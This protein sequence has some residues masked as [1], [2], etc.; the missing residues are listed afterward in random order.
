MMMFW[1]KNK[2]DYQLSHRPPL[3]TKL[4]DLTFVVFDTETTGFAIG[5]K[6]RLIEI[7][8][9][10]VEGFQVTDET[11]HTYVNPHRPI[12]EQITELTGISEE[13][14]K[15]APS[16]LEAIESFF[17]FIEKCESSGLVGHYLA[18]D[19]LVLKKE[20][21]RHKT[22][23]EDPLTFDTLDIL[24]YLVPSWEMR[25]LEEYARAF[26][27]K[28]FDRHSA[29]GDAL[30]TAHL[31][32]ELLH[33]LEEYGKGTLGDLMEVTLANDESRALQF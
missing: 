9:V 17:K 30:T 27:T 26:S 18:F 19:M 21:S 33:Y 4:R 31:F 29:I 14:V 16:S 23:F 11:F 24:G 22:T 13:H 20:L 3:N 12:P 2:L 6:D 10:K 7:G 32:V 1:K 5:A 28:I 25:D 8:A 15:D